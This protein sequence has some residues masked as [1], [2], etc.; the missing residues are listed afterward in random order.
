MK[1]LEYFKKNLLEEN[2]NSPVERKKSENIDI[3]NYV[4]VTR[5]L[6]TKNC[7]LFKLTNKSVQAH[8]FDESEIF[9]YSETKLVTYKDTK[10]KISCYKLQIALN[11]DNKEMK[12]RLKYVK[13]LLIQLLEDKKK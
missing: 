4:F 3:F 2:K 6:K 9:L 5:W 10:G 8:F 11:S 7:I 13:L 12:T 1:L